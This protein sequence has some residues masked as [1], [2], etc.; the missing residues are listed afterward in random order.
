MPKKS[1]S[2]LFESLAKQQMGETIVHSAQFQSTKSDVSLDDIKQRESNTRE[3]NRDH[4]Q[5][6][7][8]SIA[9]LGLI[10]PLVT[11]EN[12]VLLAG[13]HRFAALSLLR[14]Q[15]AETFEKH[16]PN[17]NI[18]VHRMDFDATK[19]PDRAIEI[20]ISENEARRDYSPQEAREIAGKLRDMG[21]K[22][23]PGRPKPGEKRLKPALS[24][25]F[26]KSIRTVERYLS[27][28]EKTPPNGEVSSEM[29]I[30][31]AIAKLKKW[32]KSRGRKKWE[33][34]FSKKLPGILAE[35][36]SAVSENS[37]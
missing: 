2:N 25:I 35:L 1:A 21:Y 11:D 28:D 13:G 16:F 27:T 7:C 3:L 30:K 33:V 19:E 31:Q 23:T 12:N 9:A 15:D 24:I 37:K 26:G 32:E 20:E 17:G 8:E 36:E 18:P 29:Y 6:L 34:A 14:S 4:V 5:A 10:E 22:D